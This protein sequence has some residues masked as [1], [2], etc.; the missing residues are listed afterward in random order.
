[1][2]DQL[3]VEFERERPRLRAVARR[4]LGSSADAEDAVQEAWLRISRAGTADVR[5]L[6][7]WLTT[8]VGRVALDVLRSRQARREQLA[9][10]LT[11]RPWPVEDVGPAGS[12]PAEEV[13]LAES[14]ELALTV[15][16]EELSP[17]E[18]V[19]F[20]LHDLFGV[21]FAEVGPVLARS[22][23]A[24]KMLASRARRRV[25]NAGPPVTELAR[26]HRVV[27]VFRAAAAGGDLGRL[28]AVLDPDAEA[29]ADS[30]ALAPGTPLR[31]RGADAVARRALS[32][33]PL[34]SY[35]RP[36]VV[37]G[38]PGI[39][40]RRPGRAPVALL[41]FTVRG[42]RITRLDIVVDSESLARIASS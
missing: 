42:D 36:V 21:P 10:D 35:G 34:A 41:V 5:D 22:A 4:V 28:V 24:A 31:V 30:D 40:V 20:V 19:A 26:Q 38:R 1:M 23:D 29:V 39:L 15:V 25:R 3:A 2:S 6:R 11:V 32:F 14:V 17:A 37:G 13:E 27:D 12:G 16:L 9:D 7:A 8:V 33:R 18:R